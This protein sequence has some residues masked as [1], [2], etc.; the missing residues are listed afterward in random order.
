VT[1]YLRFL[2]SFVS[3]KSQTYS[4]PSTTS[5]HGLRN[6][7]EQ[8]ANQPDPQNHHTPSVWNT[9][10]SGSTP[11]QSQPEKSPNPQASAIPAS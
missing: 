2:N 8:A 10:I 7:A 4:P 11:S 9:H 6:S 5:F 3:L 1:C